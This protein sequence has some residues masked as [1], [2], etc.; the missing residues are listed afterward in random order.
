MGLIHY[1]KRILNI[2]MQQ[3]S[4]QFRHLAL[5][6][7]SSYYFLFVA[8]IVMRL[9]FVMYTLLPM[10]KSQLISILI[11]HILVLLRTDQFIPTV[12]TCLHFLHQVLSATCIVSKISAPNFCMSMT[13]YRLYHPYVPQIFLILS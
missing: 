9:G 8:S 12:P 7:S 5:K 10:A 13:I 3:I 4:N 6:I 2:N 11:P 1:S